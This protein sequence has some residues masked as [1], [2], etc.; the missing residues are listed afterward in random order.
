MDMSQPPNPDAMTPSDSPLRYEDVETS[1]LYRDLQTAKLSTGDR[2]YDFELPLL[3]GGG[4]V[5]LSEHSGVRPVALIFG[6]Y[7]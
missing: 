6:S 1:P 4:A 5:R 7:T 2:A 3:Q